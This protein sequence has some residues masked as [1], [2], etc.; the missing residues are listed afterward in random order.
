MLA[1]AVLIRVL[2]EDSIFRSERLIGRGGWIFVGYRFRIPVAE[3][4]SPYWVGGAAEA[5]RA[6]SLDKLPQL[7]NVIRGDM[8]LVGPRPRAAAELSD[9]FAQAPDCLVA[10]PGFIS[11]QESYNSAFTDQQAE[12]VLDRHYVRNSSA[13]LDFL[14]LSEAIFGIRHADP[15]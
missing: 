5:L 4:S 13:R 11:V 7:F 2:T 9:Y 10:R 6:S 12:I 8:S 1:I 14:L 15:A 3:K